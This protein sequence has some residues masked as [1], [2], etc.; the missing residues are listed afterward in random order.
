MLKT[1]SYKEQFFKRPTPRIVFV[2]WG[3]HLAMIRDHCWWARETIGD[4]RYRILASFVQV[5]SYPL[6]QPYN[7]CF[8]LFR[9]CIKPICSFIFSLD[10]PSSSSP[11]LFPLLSDGNNFPFLILTAM[12]CHWSLGIYTGKMKFS[13][14]LHFKVIIINI[15]VYVS[16]CVSGSQTLVCIGILGLIT[17]CWVLYLKLLIGRFGVNP[18]N[19]DL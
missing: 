5:S 12:Y 8:C 18:W 16:K 13:I 19:F 9:N 4:A 3:T 7:K 2:F 15:S 14:K 11:S 17:D 6:Y 1:Y 10:L